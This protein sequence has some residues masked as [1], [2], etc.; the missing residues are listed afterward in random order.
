MIFNLP[1]ELAVKI[2]DY[3]DLRSILLFSLV[4]RQGNRLANDDVLWQQ[5]YL[6]EYSGAILVLY[7]NPQTSRKNLFFQTK[8]IMQEVTD[9]LNNDD[10]RHTL[11]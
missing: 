10:D 3:L 8:K 6:R 2:L 7:K 5:R 11:N 1:E 9:Y 4:S